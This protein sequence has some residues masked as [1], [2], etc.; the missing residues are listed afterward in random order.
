MSYVVLKI[1]HIHKCES[2]ADINSCLLTAG[3][4]QAVS[5]EEI[6]VCHSIHLRVY[7][8]EKR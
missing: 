1:L 4:T 2:R 8:L 7:K 5:N 3:G 6:G